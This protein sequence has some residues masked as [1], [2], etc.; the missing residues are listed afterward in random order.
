MKVTI[1]PYNPNWELE[2]KE[3]QSE[4]SNLLSDLHPIIEHF[5]STSVPGLSAKPIIDVLVGLRSVNEFDTLVELM[6]KNENYIYYKAFNEETP[7]RRLF[8][9]LKDH[10]TKRKFPQLFQ[11]L[12]DIPHEEIN[13]WRQAHIHVWQYESFD[14][15]RHIAF[16]EYLIQHKEVC[17]EYAQLK[18]K[19]SKENWE[20]GM[21]Y[22]EAKNNFIKMHECKAIDWFK[23][24]NH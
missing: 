18:L 7:E 17:K 3:I 12:E 14:W 6:L 21:A 13:E 2:F 10:C 9:R 5:G 15:I 16:R 24:Q 23:A 4:L 8:V 11:K 22:N 19:L 1:E 20:N